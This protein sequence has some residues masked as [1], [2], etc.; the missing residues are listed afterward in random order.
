ML[1]AAVALQFAAAGL[2]IIDPNDSWAVYA[3]TT[4]PQYLMAM[5]IAYAVMRQAPRAEFAKKRLGAA[6]IIKTA[7]VCFFIMYAGS[8]SSAAISSIISKIAGAPL[9]NSLEELIKGSDTLANF[10]M[11]G[12]AAPV[13]EELFYRKLLIGRLVRYGEKPAIIMSALVFAL[14]HGN[15]YQLF[16]AFGLGAALGYIYVRTGK[17]GYAIGLHMLINIMGGVVAPLI[18]LYKNPYAVTTYGAAILGM[19]IAGG[20]IYANNRKRIRFNKGVCELESWRKAIFFNEGVALFL[21]ACAALFVY[22]TV[23]SLR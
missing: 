21:I 14:M 4:V 15:V 23:F 10:V 16:Y 19:A 3:V 17:I 2:F 7:L 12:I 22:N 18:L 20:V 6:Q 8:L 1:A 5:P 11:I 9:K 13:A